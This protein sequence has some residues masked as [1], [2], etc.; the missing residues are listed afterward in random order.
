MK[1]F[2]I[3]RAPLNVVEYGFTIVSGEHW[4]NLCL[5]FRRNEYRVWLRKGGERK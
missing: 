4:Y 2:F 1:R 3:K 5:R